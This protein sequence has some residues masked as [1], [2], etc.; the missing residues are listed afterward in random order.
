MIALCSKADSESA[1]AIFDYIHPWFLM[2]PKKKSLQKKAYRILTELYKRH[3]DPL[4]EKF[5]VK[6]QPTVEDILR[7]EPK[8]IAE[9][10]WATR[11][12]LFR[13]VS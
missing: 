13:Y 9:P 8:A 10:A 12:A 1:N 2:D 3:D 11:L 4:L 7:F 5:F 6:A